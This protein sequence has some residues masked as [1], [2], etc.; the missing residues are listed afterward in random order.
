MSLLIWDRVPFCVYIWITDLWASVGVSPWF[1]LPLQWIYFLSLKTYFVSKCVW[2]LCVYMWLVVL[3]QYNR[4]SVTSVKGKC[5]LPHVGARNW[6]QQEHHVLLNHPSIF[7]V[8][9]FLFFISLWYL[10]P[11]F[12][13]MF[14]SVSMGIQTC[15][16]LDV[17]PAC[18]HRMLYLSLNVK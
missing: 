18:K 6:T 11:S 2:Y 10:F 7:M 14:A 12:F 8:L 1:Y 5:D 16:C 3:P 4:Y 15:C 13:Y 17:S 9:F